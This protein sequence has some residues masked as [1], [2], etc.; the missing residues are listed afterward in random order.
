MR[1]P[2]RASMSITALI[3][4]SI[5]SLSCALHLEPNGLRTGSRLLT[6]SLPGQALR[7]ASRA[8]LVAACSVSLALRAP[9]AFA[10]DSLDAAIIEVSEASYPI[11]K[12]LKAETFGPFTEKI[13]TLILG[14]DA[15]KLGASIGLGIDV[16][17]TVP[18]EK[19]DTLNGVLTEAFAELKLDSCTL[20]PLPPASLADKF[21][22]VAAEK[23]DAAKL[24]AFEEK[25][26]PSLAKLPKTD[27]AVCLPSVESLDKL[28]LAQ[29]EVGRSFG[30]E[31]GKKFSSYATPV[32][33]SRFSLGTVLPLLDDAKRLAP[34][35]TPAQ[36]AAFQAAGKRVETASKQA[37]FKAKQDYYAARTAA[38][39]AAPA[40]PA[41]DAAEAA[42][43]REA[44]AKEA[45]A[46][47]EAAAVEAAAKKKAAA[48]EAAANAEALKDAETARIAAL[49]AKRA[50]LD[51]AARA[52]K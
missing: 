48:A 21:K 34:D 12:A 10:V 50:A 51:E 42:K 52:A 37:A 35:A 25:W 43:A 44:A 11:I 13:G 2:M 41:V 49:K 26:G 45:A 17:L 30:V 15:D 33:K 46:K 19:V 38:S 1:T 47:R 39:R 6:P 8:A 22:S 36:K 9:Q 24:K 18:P 16:F 5:P 14:A 27:A 3:A 32:L 31:E 28:A 4:L 7:L 20:V 40:P 23:V 29:A